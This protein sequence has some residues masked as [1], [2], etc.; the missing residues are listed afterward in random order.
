MVIL[1]QIAIYF[2]WMLLRRES[3]DHYLYACFVLKSKIERLPEVWIMRNQIH[4]RNSTNGMDE[5]TA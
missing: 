1:K 5:L 2:L 3:Q 4:N